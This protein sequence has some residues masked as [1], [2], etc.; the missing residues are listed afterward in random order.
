M[1][2]LVYKQSRQKWLQGALGAGDLL[3][4][5]VKQVSAVNEQLKIYEDGKLVEE[6]TLPEGEYVWETLDIN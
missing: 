1:F 2:H 6:V 4:F 3:K 5:A